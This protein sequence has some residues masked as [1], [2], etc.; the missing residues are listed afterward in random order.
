MCIVRSAYL[1]SFWADRGDTCKTQKEGA[2]EA[3]VKTK[4]VVGVIG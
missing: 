4:I 3:D 1:C 2:F